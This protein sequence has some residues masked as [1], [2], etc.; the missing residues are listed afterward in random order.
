MPLFGAARI[1]Q[2]TAPRNGGVTND[3]VTSA[4]TTRRAFMSVRATIQPI[5]AATRQ[6]ITATL[7]AMIMVTIRGST[8]SGSV[9]MV[10][11][12]ARVGAPA[13]V[14]N[15]NNTSQNIGSRMRTQ[16]NTAK[17]ANSGTERSIGRWAPRAADGTATVICSAGSRA[18]ILG[19]T[20]L[21]LLDLRLDRR[22]VV[23]HDL[24]GA[25]RRAPG[26]LFDQGMDRAHAGRVDDHLLAL[27][28][29][30]EAHIKPG[31]IGMRRV[32]GDAGR[33]R[34]RGRAFGG[35]DRRDRIGLLLDQMEH[36]LL[37]VGHDQALAGGEL[38]RRVGRRLHL[39]DA[40][41]R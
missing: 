35:I 38:L 37:D 7:L 19:I 6:Q 23:L 8:R 36:R 20:A 41:L 10:A 1:S 5:G 14:V 17:P 24:D 22:R 26:L 18:E 30:H 34:D 21:D 25:E 31:G 11:K 15:A 12:L 32:L 33:S 4:R 9:I 27:D 13:S 2:A 3:A 29:E 16:R 28:A 39:H 40:L